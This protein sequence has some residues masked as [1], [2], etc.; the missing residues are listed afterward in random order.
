MNIEIKK[1]LL[2]VTLIS[3]SLSSFAQKNIVKELRQNKLGEGKVRIFQDPRLDVLI[4]E[5]QFK[6]LSVG[7][8]KVIKSSGYRVQVYTGN[9][10][11]QARTEANE[12]GKRVKEL[13]PDLSVYTSFY[14]PRWL[15][16]VG[17]F[18][19]IE[20]ADAL[21]RQLKTTGQFKEASIVKEQILIPLY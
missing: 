8:Q 21:M 5:T 17:D 2:I 19:S 16:R 4:G 14:P 12:V 3:L 10:S 11:R 7:E 15:C 1:I 20:E 18:R 6:S 9:N 13:F